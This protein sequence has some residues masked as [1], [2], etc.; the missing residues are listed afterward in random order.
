MIYFD[1]GVLLKLYTIEPESPAVR[2]FV[3]RSAK[4]IPFHALHRSETA[5]AFHLKAFRRE[6]TIEQANRAIADIE[7]DLKSGVLQPF[8]PDWESVWERCREF[9][10]AHAATTGART[11]DTLHVAC[12]R[13]QGLRDFATTDQRQAT[14]AERVGLRVVDPLVDVA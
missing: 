1:T 13:E 2:R 11:L 7:D 8:A 9:S 12:A 3:E 6:C 5:S 10:T 4:A 14:M